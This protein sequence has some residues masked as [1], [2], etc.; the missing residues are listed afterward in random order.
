MKQ[1]HG[2]ALTGAVLLTMVGLSATP[3]LAAPEK[4]AKQVAEEKKREKKKKR[5]RTAERVGGGAA[6]GAVVGGAVAGGKG[7]AGG[8]AAGS[9][10]GYV[11]DR[12]A[13]E[14]DKKKHKEQ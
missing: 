6:A 13:R 3:A 11:W 10:A 1:L 12:K 5:I 8:A 7:A 4:D 2:I 9:G 14:K